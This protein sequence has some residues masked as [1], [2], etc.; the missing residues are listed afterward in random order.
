MLK[1]SL[2]QKLMQKL[3]P[4]Q[5]QLIKLL[6]LPAIQL[7]QRIKKEIEENPVL[8]EGHPQ[9]AEQQEDIQSETENE[10]EN[11]DFEDEFSLD[12]YIPDDDDIPAYKLTVNNYSKDDK[13]PEIPYSEGYSLQE[14]LTEQLG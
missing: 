2:S 9:D 8:E 12:D 4:Q 5:I 7:E 1:Q 11:N 3:S 10:N 14:Y 13:V 6:E